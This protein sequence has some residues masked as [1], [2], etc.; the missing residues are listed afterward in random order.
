MLAQCIEGS[1]VK[2]RTDA[3][4]YDRWQRPAPELLQGTGTCENLAEGSDEGG[5]AGLLDTGFEEVGR[6][7]ERGGQAAG[8]E[9]GEE[10]ERWRRPLALWGLGNDISAGK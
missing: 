1:E 3:C 2:R 6:L 7:E 8:C 4:T 5:R 10:V 9:T